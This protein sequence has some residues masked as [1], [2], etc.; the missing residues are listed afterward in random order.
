[1][2][3]RSPFIEVV[4]TARDGQEALEMVEQLNPDVVTCDLIMPVMDGG[5][6]VREL[7]RSRRSPIVIVSTAN[8]ASEMP[9][10]ALVA[11]A[12]DFVPQPTAL[13]T[14]K[15]FEVSGESIE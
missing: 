4:D 2:L 11:G 6:P 7:M 1:M 9:L 8:E 15:I 3:S 14:Q 12:I 5:A 10:T 13:A